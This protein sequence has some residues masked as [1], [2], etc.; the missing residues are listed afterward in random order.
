MA[1][2]PVKLAAT[3]LPDT[4]IAPLPPES[5]AMPPPSDAVAFDTTA[6]TTGCPPRC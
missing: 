3:P 5:T 4:S 2:V 1:N 6:I